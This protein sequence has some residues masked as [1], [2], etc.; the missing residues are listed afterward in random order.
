MVLYRYTFESGIGHKNKVPLPWWYV[1]IYL[2]WDGKGCPMAVGKVILVTGT[3][4]KFK[5]GLQTGKWMDAPSFCVLPMAKFCHGIQH[6]YTYRY[7]I[8][9][10]SLQIKY[11]Y[12][13]ADIFLWKIEIKIFTFHIWKWGYFMHEL[14]DQ[15]CLITSVFNLM[16]I[17]QLTSYPHL[18][19]RCIEI[20]IQCY[21]L[22]SV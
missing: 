17:I 15:S 9:F 13:G 19:Y 18:R 6:T 14:T 8:E 3:V 5:T 1:T 16:K 7:A 10:Q 4:P 20:Q 2:L 11:V 21:N 12:I 22:G